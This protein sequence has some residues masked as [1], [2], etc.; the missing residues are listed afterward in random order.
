MIARVKG[1]SAIAQETDITRN[2]IKKPWLNRGI[3]G[4]II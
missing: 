1:I 4:L 3:S 2:E